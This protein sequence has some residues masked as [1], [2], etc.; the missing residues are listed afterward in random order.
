MN[1]DFIQGSVAEVERL[2]SKARGVLKGDDRP[3]SPFSFEAILFLRQNESFWDLNS[4][5]QTVSAL[6]SDKV[7]CRMEEDAEQ[8]ALHG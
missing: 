1:G 4:I 7:Q 5:I 6:R 8:E 3:L 2:W